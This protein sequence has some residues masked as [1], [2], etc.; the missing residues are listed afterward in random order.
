MNTAKE[1]QSLARQIVEAAVP[2]AR[3]YDAC[4]PQADVSRERIMEHAEQALGGLLSR[5]LG[6]ATPHRP[7]APGASKSCGAPP[8]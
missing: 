3:A 1:P 4:G 6:A 8:P 7:S 2:I 5:F